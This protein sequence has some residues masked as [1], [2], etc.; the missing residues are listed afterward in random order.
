MLFQIYSISI[1]ILKKSERIRNGL[2]PKYFVPRPQAD[3]VGN[4]SKTFYIGILYP[5][6]VRLALDIFSPSRS[7]P[8]HGTR[9]RV[10]FLSMESTKSESAEFTPIRCPYPRVP[11]PPQDHAANRSLPSARS[12]SPPRSKS[13]IRSA[14]TPTP[15][16]PPSS[17]PR[18]PDVPPSTCRWRSHRGH[19]LRSWDP[20]PRRRPTVRVAQWPPLRAIRRHR[21]PPFPLQHRRL[22]P[23]DTSA[24]HSAAGGVDLT[25]MSDRPPRR[26]ADLAKQ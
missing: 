18:K 20:A 1:S 9:A 15:N 6:L 23:S 11:P 26:W 21:Q 4:G 8:A 16:A 3:P 7:L 22:D 17:P 25:E 24:V 2:S 13:T 5:C 12:P 14:T 10:Y 19:S